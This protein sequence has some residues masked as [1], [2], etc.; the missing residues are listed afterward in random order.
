MSLAS[1]ARRSLLRT[2]RNTSTFSVA[3]TS[4]RPAALSHH[5]LQPAFFKPAAS[6]SFTASMASSGV[7]NLQAKA[8]FDSAR[9][10]TGTLMVVDFFATWCGP[11]KAI[12]PQVVKMSSTYPSARFYKIDVDEVPEV[13]QELS[14]RAMPTFVLFKDGQE[15]ATV[16]GANP[17]ALEAAIKQHV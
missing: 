10:E 17:T 5:L 4:T 16:V 9:A 14:I 11:C 13:A 8:D 12:A 6:R 7:H 1:S 15:V 3:R 2:A